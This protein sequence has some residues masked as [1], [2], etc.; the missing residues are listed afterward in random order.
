[1][2]AAQSFI[3]WAAESGVRALTMSEQAH[4]QNLL[5][6]PSEE[7]ISRGMVE[8]LYLTLVKAQAALAPRPLVFSDGKD[9]PTPFPTAEEEN[10]RAE[11]RI[12]DFIDRLF[13][14]E[15]S[16][17]REDREAEYAARAKAE[18]AE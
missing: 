18:G 1:M 13:D 8:R 10:E 7:G 5:Q 12:D 4:L 9:D 3:D 6:F 15:M 17:S 2:S 14:E 16:A 11:R